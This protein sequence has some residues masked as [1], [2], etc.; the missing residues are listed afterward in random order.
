MIT[1][2]I[3]VT[4]SPR[5][6]PIS[7]VYGSDAVGITLTI[8]DFDLPVDATAVVRARGRRAAAAY[9]TSCTVSGN[10]VIFYPTEG[11]FVPGWNALQIKVSVN[12][13]KLLSFPL[14]AFCAADLSVENEPSSPEALSTFAELLR[15]IAQAEEKIHTLENSS[16][17]ASADLAP[18]VYCWGDSLTQGEG[19]NLKLTDG[20]FNSFNLHPYTA[21]LTG[22][23]AV[24]LG[25]Q[26]EDVITIM[27]RQGADPMVVGGFTI[28][29]ECTPV[30]VGNKT[31]GIPTASGG[32]ARPLKPM[33]AGI[34]PCTIAGV[35][36]ILHRGSSRNDSDGNY[37]F[38]RLEAGSATVVPAGSTLTTFAMAHYRSGMAVIWMGAN[39]GHSGVSDFCAKVKRMVAYGGY[40]DYLVLLAREFHGADAEV[41][42][43]ALTDADGKCHVLNLYRELPLHGLSLANMTHYYFD[44]SSYANGDEILLKAPMLC[45]CTLENGSPKFESLHFSAYGYKAIGKLV[46][47]RL[48]EAGTTGG[49]TGGD[50]PPEEKIYEENVTDSHGLVLWRLKNAVT[51][52]GNKVIDTGWAPYDRKKNW[53]IAVKVQDGIGGSEDYNSIFE[54]RDDTAGV[55]T[56]LHLRVENI[57]GTPVFNIGL[58]NRKGFSVLKSGGL[59]E[60]V[61]G[62]FYTDGSHYCVISNNGGNYVIAFDGGCWDGY[63]APLEGRFTEDTLCL[64]ARRM[65]D[66]SFGQYATGTIEEFRIYDTSFPAT[67]CKAILAEMKGE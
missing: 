1:R 19:S 52:T 47:A 28:P 4:K 7:V 30:T 17:G 36:G 24:N 67:E 53:T 62:D 60:W 41:V 64:F 65:P 56:S 49:G 42:A 15:R 2:D 55:E 10:S 61:G 13:R 58:G 34:N 40:S 3:Y 45:A 11:L 63:G 12:N 5:I 29:A 57:S 66:G 39:G 38:T 25:C 8:Q 14:D 50:E 54:S 6:E 46:A 59:F 31:D 44:T 32:T 51:S 43:A 18:R 48:A 9:Q 35:R 26:G 37:Y 21:E 23:R 20:V 16:G 27:A 22:Y 33:E